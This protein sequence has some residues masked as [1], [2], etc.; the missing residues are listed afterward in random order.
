MQYVVSV[1]C[2]LALL[3]FFAID[4]TSVQV[5]GHTVKDWA[6]ND[7][8]TNITTS[9][10]TD[11]HRHPELKR[12]L[13]STQAECDEGE[14]AIPVPRQ[15]LMRSAGSTTIFKECESQRPRIIN[16]NADVCTAATPEPFALGHH[17][18]QTASTTLEFAP[19]VLRV[20]YSLRNP[21]DGFQFVLPNDAYPYVS[22][23]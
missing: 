2:I 14:L 7:P 21:V 6:H 3:I 12:K 15:V 16:A 11:C 17:V 10:I 9:D 5:G 18:A 8:M 13:Y 20:A 1:L 4:I 19:I 23:S 22:E